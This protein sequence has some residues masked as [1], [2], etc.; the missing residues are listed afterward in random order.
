MRAASFDSAPSDSNSWGGDLMIVDR[1]RLDRLQ[2]GLL[3]ARELEVLLDDLL[4]EAAHVVG[5]RTH[6]DASG[7][8]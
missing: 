1:M 2:I 5:D 7:T 8:L 6:R 3:L 4:K